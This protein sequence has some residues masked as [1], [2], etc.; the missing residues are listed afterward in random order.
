M[1]DPPNKVRIFV[2]SLDE[3][4]LFKCE[5]PSVPPLVIHPRRCAPYPILHMGRGRPMRQLLFGLRRLLR[6][7]ECVPEVHTDP[8]YARSSH[9]EMSTS[10]L[11][12]L[13]CDGWGYGEGAC[14]F[15]RA[16]EWF[17]SCK[18]LFSIGDLYD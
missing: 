6:E 14:S 1:G 8:A 3:P 13:W 9:W 16:H 4:D 5:G 7:G 11:S 12:S 10:Q 17:F 18:L 2:L 15:F